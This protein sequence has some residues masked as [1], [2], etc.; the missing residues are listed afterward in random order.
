LALPFGT[1]AAYGLV[2]HRFRFQ[3]I[4]HS[5]LLLPITMPSIVFGVAFF[6]LYIRVGLYGSLS[7]LI[8][9]HSLLGLPFVVTV[10]TASLR[11]LGRD[12]EEA[13]MDLGAD[14]VATFFRVVVPLI[15]PSLVVGAIFAF[16][17]SFDQVD[18]S[19]FL[20]R[21]QTNTLPIEMFIYAGSYQDP[22]L[23][24]VSALMILV[25][26]VLVGM[27]ALILKTQEYRRFLERR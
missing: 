11:T 5:I 26:V 6:L 7:G 16:I 24:A 19:L 23:S 25:T 14:S 4:A 15:R 8:L 21:P 20:V 17:V 2:R 1:L 27:G 13:A 18:V 3:E 12:Y 9:A 22:T 10:V